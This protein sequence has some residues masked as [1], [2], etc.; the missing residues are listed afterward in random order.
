MV[1]VPYKLPH[2]PIKFFQNGYNKR[3]VK[4]LKRGYN[5]MLNNKKI[6]VV[7]PAY[8]AASTLEKTYQEIPHN[9]IDDV[10]IGGR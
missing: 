5:E 6:I 3:Q 10:I 4:Y 9:I 7:M 1:I 8:N 2:R